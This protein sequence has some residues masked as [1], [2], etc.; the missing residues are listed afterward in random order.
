MNLELCVRHVL[1]CLDRSSCMYETTRDVGDRRLAV[2][3]LRR[4]H[5]STSRPSDDAEKPM[6]LEPARG[7][8]VLDL[9]LEYPTLGGPHRWN[10]APAELFFFLP[11][12]IIGQ[13]VWH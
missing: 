8:P 13:H 3:V 1:H 7:T 10:N 12:P 11:D 5:A 2:L 9:T 6:D 4:H